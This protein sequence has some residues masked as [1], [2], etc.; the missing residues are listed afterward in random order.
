MSRK[1]KQ[2]A[3]FKR[4]QTEQNA[5]AIVLRTSNLQKE[6]KKSNHKQTQTQTIKTKSET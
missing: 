4:K 2:R 3:A 5:S 1:Q 6:I